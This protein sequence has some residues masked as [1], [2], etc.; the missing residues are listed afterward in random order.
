MTFDEEYL[1]KKN[2]KTLSENNSLHFQ[3]QQQPTKTCNNNNHNNATS[4]TTFEQEEQ[5]LLRADQSH[6]K[7]V[8]IS[9][10]VW[11]KSGPGKEMR[12]RASRSTLYGV[13]MTVLEPP[14]LLAGQCGLFAARPFL[15]FD[16]VGE[17]CGDVVPATGSTTNTTTNSSSRSTTP[18]PQHWEYQAR[19]EDKDL[20]P[21]GVDAQFRGNECRAINHFE[22]IAKAPNVVMKIGYVELLPRVLIICKRDIAKGEEFLLNYGDDYADAYLRGSNK[23]QGPLDEKEENGTSVQVAWSEMAGQEQ[24]GDD[25]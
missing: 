11:P 21:L 14:H 24:D 3:T 20:Y 1:S 16:I 10:N 22:N 4:T 7:A 15:Q 5:L 25:E 23:E 13:E 6:K 19:L 18:H 8:R 9:A 17:Y 12:K 2:Q